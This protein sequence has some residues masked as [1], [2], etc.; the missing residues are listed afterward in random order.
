V[1]GQGSPG[2]KPTGQARDSTKESLPS[3][4]KIFRENRSKSHS[5]CKEKIE[6][7]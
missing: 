2:L 1:Q 3:R 5:D 7:E 6:I 4:L